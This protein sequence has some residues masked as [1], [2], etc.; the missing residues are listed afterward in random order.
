ML[1]QLLELLKGAVA[2]IAGIAVTN[3]GLQQLL[4]L[5]LRAEYYGKCRSCRSEHGVSAIGGLAVTNTKVTSVTGIVDTSIAAEAGLCHHWRY[6]R[7]WI[8]LLLTLANDRNW[9]L[10]FMTVAADTGFWILPLVCSLAEQ[11]WRS[12]VAKLSKDEYWRVFCAHD[13]AV[14]VVVGIVAVVAWTNY[15]VWHGLKSGPG[16]IRQS[17]RTDI[18]VLSEFGRSE[19]CSFATHLLSLYAWPGNTWLQFG[20]R[21]DLLDC[22]A[23][24]TCR[25]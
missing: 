5:L 19:L 9:D 2:A 23:A 4:G 15:E 3:R 21:I 8:K 20:S 14:V 7:Y 1:Q 6:S 17:H 25:C 12:S 24:S 11:H 13:V 10:S 16:P 22:I 18:P